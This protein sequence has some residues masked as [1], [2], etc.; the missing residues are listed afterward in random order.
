VANGDRI[1]THCN[2]GSLGTVEFGTALGIIRTASEKKK[3]IS[4]VATETRPLLQ[5]A[6]LTTWEL[7][8]YRIPYR[9]ICDSAA[10]YVM[11]KKMVD[12]VLV[13]ADRV[14]S[15]GHVINKIGTLTLAVLA[16][17]YSIPFYVAAPLSTFDP[18]SRPE[19]VPIEERN[20]DEVTHFLGKRITAGGTKS[21]N[22]AFDITPPEYISGIITETSIIREPYKKN[23]KHELLDIKN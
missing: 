13:G 1:L 11:S 18:S 19:T 7:K 12:K 2:T 8:R 10:G 6:R 22:P 16:K 14:L 5:G 9:I 4:V 15:T 20:S 17:N 21:I 23:I 3:N